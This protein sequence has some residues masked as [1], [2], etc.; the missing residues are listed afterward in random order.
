M[1]ENAVGVFQCLY[2][3]KII[4]REKYFYRDRYYKSK[5]LFELEKL[6]AEY[7][8]K[9]YM[10][11]YQYSGLLNSEYKRSTFYF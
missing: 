1:I 2:R 11:K 3:I 4:Y 5:E 9:F 8:Y 10:S 7:I 6:K